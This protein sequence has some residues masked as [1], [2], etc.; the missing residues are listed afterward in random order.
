V[1]PGYSPHIVKGW[2]TPEFAT[3]GWELT[4]AL[5]ARLRDDVV[6]SGARFA[7][8]LIPSRIQVLPGLF[9]LGGVLYAD[10]PDV[11]QFIADPLLPQKR[12]AAF[13]AAEGI[14]LL[15]LQPVLAA[16]EPAADLYFPVI[17]HWNA[18]GNRVAT[19]AMARFL[20]REGLSGPRS[21]R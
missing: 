3:R 6:A 17:A 21:A 10:A 16:S 2:Y 20:A 9:E 14:P 12:M 13:A 1:H 8:V 15:D 19:D 11:Q 4:Q 7:I 5:L 18:A